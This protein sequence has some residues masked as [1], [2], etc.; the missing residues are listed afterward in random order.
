MFNADCDNWHNEDP[1]FGTALYCG[2]NQGTFKWRYAAI[3]GV[4]SGAFLDLLLEKRTDTDNFTLNF[5]DVE[6]NH[7]H[8]TSIL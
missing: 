8:H 3:P 2:C 7:L 1:L 6:N 4:T 5:C